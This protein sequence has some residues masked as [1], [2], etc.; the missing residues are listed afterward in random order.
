M[1]FADSVSGLD[2][3]A[4]GA[5]AVCGSHGGRL[6]GIEALRAGV[7]AL[8]VH[9]AGVGLDAAGIVALPLLDEWDIPCASVD[10][11]SARIGD[12]AH[13]GSHGVLSHVNAAAARRGACPGQRVDEA[14]GVLRSAPLVTT[15]AQSD[16][17]ALVLRAPRRHRIV[18]ERRQVWLL[19]S[20]SQ[21]DERHE[22]AVIVTGSHGA[23]LGGRPASA[24]R[25]PAFAAVFNDAGCV[26]SRLSAL[27]AAG[28][29]AVTVAANSARIGDAESTLT[30]G[31]VSGVNATA[32]RIGASIGAR[33]ALFA[34]LTARIA[35]IPQL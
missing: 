13:I 5:V 34:E 17:P 24:I 26:A 25:V 35:A 27:E 30:Q 1:V 4:R 11:R 12:A 31:F 6:S 10:Y 29:A 21:V 19:D 15:S 7:A 8:I 23:L 3:T 14:V 28:I 33:V 22:G 20:V 16:D 32:E 2:V 9:D 18:G